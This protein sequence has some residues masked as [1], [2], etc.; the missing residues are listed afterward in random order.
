MFKKLKL[1]IVKS[2]IN[3]YFDEI[4]EY[5]F[6]LAKAKGEQFYKSLTEKLKNKF[7]AD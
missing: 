1:K 3:E 2:F 5:I 6:D 7:Q 4:S